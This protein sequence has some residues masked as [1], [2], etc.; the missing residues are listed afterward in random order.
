MS[1]FLSSVLSPFS[2]NKIAERQLLGASGTPISKHWVDVGHQFDKVFPI[3]AGGPS[4]GLELPNPMRCAKL[5]TVYLRQIILNEAEP[6]AYW[7]L[8]LVVLSCSDVRPVNLMCH[9]NFISLRAV[10]I[11][12]IEEYCSKICIEC[13]IGRMPKP[14]LQFNISAKKKA[15]NPANE[16]KQKIDEAKIQLWSKTSTMEREERV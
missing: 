4:M 10:K 9:N 13:G 11:T 3:F 14:Y 2:G 12:K 1:L 15:K 6:E 16:R 5:S 8:V 7:G